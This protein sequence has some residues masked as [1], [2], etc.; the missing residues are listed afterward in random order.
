ME[1][2]VRYT[3]SYYKNGSR[4]IFDTAD[5]AIRLKV[6]IKSKLKVYDVVLCGRAELDREEFCAAR[7]KFTVLKD[8]VISFNQGDAVSVKYDGK[9][10]FYG[11]VFTKKRDK[12]G[13]I[14]VICYDQLRYLKNRRTYTRGRMRLD[15]AVSKIAA[16]CSLSVG[17]IARSGVSLPSV[18]ADNVSLL[19]VVVKACKDTKRLTGERFILYDDAGRLQLKNERDMIVGLMIDVAGAE[20]FTYRDSIDSDVYNQIQ[21]Y[22]DTKK[23]NLRRISV[24]SDSETMDM[25]G[26]LILSKKAADPENAMEEAK[27]LLE[28]YNRVNREIVLERVPGNEEF[29]PGCSVYVKLVMGDLDIDRYVRVRRAVHVFENN[30]YTTDLYL[31]GSVVE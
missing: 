9:S 6:Y 2:V 31:D 7:F 10:I 3:N 28:E 4:E 30:G 16:D 12:E 23:L 29:L 22:S 21:I 19:D 13:L 25:W 14:E 20:N 11:Y 18:A 15:E 17:E 5:E 26:T 27:N 24:V 8:S 1:T